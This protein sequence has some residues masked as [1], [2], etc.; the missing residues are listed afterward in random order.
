M[1]R[2]ARYC[3]P[4][5][6][7]DRSR[8]HFQNDRCTVPVCRFL[9]PKQKT[10]IVACAE[11]NHRFSPVVCIEKYRNHKLCGNLNNTKFQKA[12]YY[13]LACVCLKSYF[14]LYLSMGYQ[15]LS[16]LSSGRHV[17]QVFDIN[18]IIVYLGFIKNLDSAT[19]ELQNAY[20][21]YALHYFSNKNDNILLTESPLNTR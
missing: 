18:Q 7:I 15:L 8:E 6:K 4:F 11:I 19:R 20:L 17:R 9:F 3:G 5:R 14:S 21:I 2:K 12:I 1:H 10:G 13:L 16:Y